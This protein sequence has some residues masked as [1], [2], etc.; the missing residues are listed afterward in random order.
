MSA[1]LRSGTQYKCPRC[2]HRLP[3]PSILPPNLAK[4]KPHYS[5]R[6]AYLSL[7]LPTAEHATKT[8]QPGMADPMEQKNDVTASDVADAGAAGHG[9]SSPSPDPIDAGEERRRGI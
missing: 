4:K 5:G 2:L 6:I 1:G 7:S 8:V 3:P 9:G